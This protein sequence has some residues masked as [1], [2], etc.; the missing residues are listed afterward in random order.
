MSAMVPSPVRKAR[1]DAV[2]VP[3]R[4]SRRRQPR[5]NE[6]LV[7]SARY[8]G[9]GRVYFDD[10]HRGHRDVPPLPWR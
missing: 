3:G 5:T 10:V 2:S 6:S 7:A 8:D 4:L 1:R 9:W